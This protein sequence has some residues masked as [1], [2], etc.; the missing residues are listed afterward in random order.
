MDC[1]YLQREEDRIFCQLKNSQITKKYVRRVCIHQED[2]ATCIKAVEAF[3]EADRL[4]E[5]N[6]ISCLTLYR[7]ASALFASPQL[8]D[9]LKAILSRIKLIMFQKKHEY[10]DQALQE[11][12][13]VKELYNNALKS[14]PSLRSSDIGEKIASL[15]QSLQV[16][17]NQ[18]KESGGLVRPSAVLQTIS[19]MQVEA[20][21]GHAKHYSIEEAL[22]KEIETVIEQ[23]VT[24]KVTPE[25]PSEPTETSP[26]TEVSVTTTEV[27]ETTEEVPTVEMPTVEN[28]ITIDTLTTE[29]GGIIESVETIEEA[30]SSMG[31]LPHY[32]EKA[33]NYEKLAKKQI[34]EGKIAAAAKYTALSSISWILAGNPQEGLI[35]LNKLLKESKGKRQA[36]K[37]ESIFIIARSLIL[38]SF[39]KDMGKFYEAELLIRQLKNDYSDEEMELIGQGLKTVQEL[40][41]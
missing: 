27:G 35:T 5:N 3:Q 10:Y 2:S 25:P 19:E 33:E 39:N 38:A 4:A 11:A 30:D 13:E 41:E 40:I 16:S 14:T 17:Y 31:F 8:K 21:V 24:G 26:A 23:E 9:F 1:R 18:S 36:V 34:S 12:K 32:R 15:E 29:A 28:E 37:K 6:N 7:E 20:A 22:T